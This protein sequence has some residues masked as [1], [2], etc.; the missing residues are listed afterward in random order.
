MNTPDRA[1][2]PPHR[3]PQDGDLRDVVIL[4]GSLPAAT[5]A[6]VLAAGGARVTVIDAAQPPPFPPGEMGV[7]AAG[8]FRVL[9]ERYKAPELARL[10]TVKDI[11]TH[12]TRTV[13]AE[14]CHSFVYHREG[15]PQDPAELLQVCPPKGAPPEPHFHRPDIDAYLLR[16]AR[17]RGADVR[18]GGKVSGAA[19]GPDGAAVR[20]SDGTEVRARYLVDASGPDSPLVSALGLRQEPAPFATAS[21]TLAAH[22]TGVRP[23][24]DAVADRAA[25]YR[26]ALPW[27]RGSMHHLTDGAYLAV[28][29]LGNHPDSTG[30]LFSVA[31]T[32][33]ARRFP[34]R[35]GPGR[36]PEEEFR[37]FVARFPTLVDQFAYAAAEGPWLATERNQYAASR[38]VG[39]R[40][41]LIGDAAGYVDPFISR[42][43]GLTLEAVNALARRLLDAVRDGDFSTERFAEVGELTR[44]QLAAND[45]LAAMVHAS[46]CDPA[47][48]RAVLFVLEA[49]FRFGGFPLL[50]A[51]SELRS[52]GGDAAL[53]ALE[54]VPH[55]GHVFAGHEGYHRLFTA[56]GATCAAVA[57]GELDARTASERIFRS[58]RE[59][60]FVP[61]AFKLDDPAAR[62]L[63]ITPVTLL[64]LAL[65]SVTGA[66]K[67]IAPLVRAGIKSVLKGG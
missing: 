32:L 60:E 45:E 4:G 35:E 58:V 31:L 22:M 66:P 50:A 25:A 57:A 6:T 47:L 24:A 38:T 67:D 28:L 21:R 30:G 46:L 26:P 53:R 64:R 65:W 27:H 14:H 39:D 20:L 2:R 1:P 52:T 59:A 13:G 10:A 44:D 29:P 7:H 33:D 43:L 49:G 8:L 19:A 61:A 34:P 36:T 16:C 3:R 40:W 15:R 11:H 63:R 5:L 48:V 23:F 42:G 41:C 51:W 54:T 62:S 12:V 9:A 18:R 55:R 56:A 17:E 37:A